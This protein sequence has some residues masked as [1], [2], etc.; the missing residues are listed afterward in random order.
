MFSVDFSLLLLSL[1]LMKINSPKGYWVGTTVFI[2][3]IG[4]KAIA[5]IYAFFLH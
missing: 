5:D 3:A 2:S 4:Q 1:L